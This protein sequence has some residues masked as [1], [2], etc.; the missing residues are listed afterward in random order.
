M[1]TRVIFDGGGSKKS[2]RCDTTNKNQ[3][4]LIIKI[5]DKSGEFYGMLAFSH[6]PRDNP[7]RVSN[8]YKKS[9]WMGLIS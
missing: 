2:I 7:K 6:P 4:I 8:T 5:E 1:P 3:A 9:K